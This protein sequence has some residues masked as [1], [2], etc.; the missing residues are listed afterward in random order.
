MSRS[1]PQLSCCSG[2]RVHVVRTINLSVFRRHP[3]NT[4]GRGGRVLDD[5]SPWSSES[6]LAQPRSPKPRCCY[7]LRLL[8]S[9]AAVASRPRVGSSRNDSRISRPRPPRPLRR[10]R[11]CHDGIITLRPKPRFLRPS[12]MNAGAAH[13]RPCPQKR[14]RHGRAARSSLSERRV[15]S[16]ACRALHPSLPRSTR[17]QRPRS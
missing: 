13:R 17:R 14:A 3:S 10:F 7:R 1:D 15:A 8:P 12:L 6:T 2:R 9:S 4:R 11:F 5:L 16:S